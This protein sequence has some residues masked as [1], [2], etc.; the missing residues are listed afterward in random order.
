MAF[1]D[2]EMGGKRAEF[3]STH[4]SVLA[5]VRGTI[6]PAHRE[7]INLL[8]KRYWKPVYCYLRR[9]GHGN[10]GAKDLVQEFFAQ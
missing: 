4:W 6:T 9:R 3:P 1:D 2:T 7:A 8:I 5:A 10:E